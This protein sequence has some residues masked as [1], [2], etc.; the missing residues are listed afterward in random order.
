MEPGQW[1]A[2]IDLATELHVQPGA[3]LALV[4]GGVTFVG[5]VIDPLERTTEPGRWLISLIPPTGLAHEC[6]IEF[7]P[8]LSHRLESDLLTTE[9]AAVPDAVVRRLLATDSLTRD[10]Q[11]DLQ[12]RA[13]RMAWLPGAGVLVLLLAVVA[14][15]RRPEAGLY[16]VMG[17]TSVD[18]A[19]LAFVETTLLVVAASALGAIWAS[20]VHQSTSTHGVEFTEMAFGLRAAC[21]VAMLTVAV[22]P[23]T[24]IALG[25]EPIAA[26]L[27]D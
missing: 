7:A 2:G 10:P 14:R 16:K 23:L 5:A 3:P 18:M 11:Q 19:M 4:G 22:A 20:C 13:T 1:A 15:A 12:N 17:A 27:K 26:Q 8:G 9:F 6:W 21:T 24:W 25:R